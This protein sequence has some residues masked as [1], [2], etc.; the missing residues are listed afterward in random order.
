[1]WIIADR[2]DYKS[3]TVYF[4]KSSVYRIDQAIEQFRKL[5]YGK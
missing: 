1:M 5:V 3:T 2:E 4:F